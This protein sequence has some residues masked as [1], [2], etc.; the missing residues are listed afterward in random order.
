VLA[1]WVVA[2]VV[3]WR[4]PRVIQRP[5]K[6]LIFPLEI[7]MSGRKRFNPIQRYARKDISPYFWP[8]GK[9]PDSAECQRHVDD[10][11]RDYKLRITGLV[12]NPLDL[13]LADI[14][15]LGHD[16][17]VGL[18][19][20]IQGC[21]RIAHWG[22]ISMVRLI[23]LVKPQPS[24]HVVEFISFG[25]GLYG[26]VSYDTQRLEDVVKPECLFAYEMNDAPLPLVHGA[27]LR[28]RIENQ[29]GFKMVK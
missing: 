15:A 4:Y 12:D 29:L 7:S 27:P 6:A 19:P 17:H 23:E 26:G 25:E 11:F 3:A 13:T 28:L 5:H 22:G 18:H 16:E 1:S 21:S 14:R 24:A 8:N 9:I 2:Y 20:C 10:G